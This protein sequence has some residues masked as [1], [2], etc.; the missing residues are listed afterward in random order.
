[1]SSFAKPEILTVSQITSSIKLLL[2]DAYRFVH[3]RGEVSNLRRPHSGHLYFTLKDDSAQLKTVLFKGQQKFLEKTIEDGQQ[4]VCHGRIS[5]Y[6]QRGDY[7]LIVDTVDFQGSGRLYIE[8]ERLKNKLREEG[9][10]DSGRKKTIPQFP[11][12]I[13]VITSP[14]GA[15]IQD[16]LKICRLRRTNSTIKIFP[17]R[18]QGEG[19]GQEISRAIDRV[20]KELSPDLIV[21]CRGGGSLEDLWAFNEECVARAISRSEIPIVTG[22]GHEIDFT[23]ADFCSDLRAPTPTAAAEQ[24]LFDTNMLADHIQSL[25]RRIGFSI[26][27][28]LDSY[29]QQ[30]QSF[31]KRI[32]N[33]EPL[34]IH[35]SLDLDMRFS[36]F[37]DLM[38][39]RL[40]KYQTHF[41]Q[42]SITL[43]HQA[44]NLKLQSNR[45]RLIHLHERLVDRIGQLFDKKENDFT[46]Q[47][48][49]LDAV[50]P[51][52]TLARGYSITR[53][54][55]NITG[56]YKVVS[57]SDQV[58]IRDRLQIILNQ[59][60][61]E[62]EVVRKEKKGL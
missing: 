29:T 14:T 42:L 59:G 49:L 28:L 19:S 41:D 17:V 55:D 50:S 46:R 32:G 25:I 3:I 44:P 52:A 27:T 58:A 39:K 6:D 11:R 12:E 26:S 62:C 23:I 43:R 34:F 5:V 4:L 13:V 1:M 38:N 24:V 57:D 54:K 16:F 45:E 7:Q 30:V 33:L 15:A 51:L 10:F 36:R 20:N 48:M 2:E 22:I 47:L 61:L 31:Q 35:Y 56:H 37:V 53:K 9:L 8:F 21:L 40:L 18:V 60:R